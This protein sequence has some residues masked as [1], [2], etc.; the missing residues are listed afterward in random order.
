MRFLKYMI[1][2][3]GVVAIILFYAI[4]FPKLLNGGTVANAVALAGILGPLGIIGFVVYEKF[5]NNGSRS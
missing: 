5:T 4:G 1:A 2:Y 3:I